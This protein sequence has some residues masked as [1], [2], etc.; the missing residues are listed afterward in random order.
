MSDRFKL[1]QV[2][3]DRSLRDAMLA[4]EHG[5]AEIALVVNGKEQLV[6]T[7]TD[8]DIRRAILKGCGLD[9]P[10][11]PYMERNFTA[12]S[13]EA[14]RTEVIELMQARFIRQIP[15]VAENNR[16]VGLHLMHEL[17]GQPVRA[18]WAVIMAGGLGTRLRPIT[19]T[20]P[21]PMIRVAGRPIL[22][23]IVLHLVG[24][25]FREIFISVNYLSH[26][27]EEHFGNGERF[28]CR[29]S[30]LHEDEQL[31]TGGALALLPNRPAHPVLV[32]NGDLVTQIQAD[33]L[34]DFHER[35]G[36][37]ATLCIRRYLHRVPFGCLSISEQGRLLGL[38][39][40]PLLHRWINA[41]IYLLSPQ[42]LQLVPK[43]YFPLTELFDQL[44][45]D[46]AAVGAFEIEDDWIDVGQKEQLATARGQI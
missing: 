39:E 42:A 21:K 41:G 28:G 25:G 37:A 6:G 27:I 30:Y 43:R 44:V 18:N 35:G 7:L 14:S 12:V 19:E 9:T 16:L 34:L 5:A 24:F 45:K 38:E 46:G 2:Y 20:L 4:L 8:G 26:I 29:I 1:C 40:K 13:P 23:R 3:A 10:L 15:V 17:I 36:F 31:G 11:E 33:K 32:M 22:E